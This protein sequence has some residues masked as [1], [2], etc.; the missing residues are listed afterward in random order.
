MPS[1]NPATDSAGT[2]NAPAGS[3]VGKNE[4]NTNGA[5]QSTNSSAV[6]GSGTAAKASGAE[7][8][9]QKKAE[10]AARRQ[11]EIQARQ[12]GSAASTSASGGKPQPQNTQ[13]QRVK[14]ESGA[15]QH[16][17]S[18]SS[19]VDVRNTPSKGGQSATSQP[20]GPRKE[21]K[22][23]E[24]FRHLYKARATTISGAS[25][26]VHPAILALGQQMS[27]YTIC[28]SNARLVATLQAFKRV[29]PRF[30][31]MSLSVFGVSFLCWISSVHQTRLL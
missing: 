12:S 8:K 28:G 20:E 9:A 24:L 10:K 22:T 23:V 1:S 13:P 14:G 4:P 29:S 15:G 5:V 21:D 6:G 2:E 17:R 26:D 25:K 16:R 31:L 19:A 11:R 30:Y 27:S 7:I 18:S 3:I